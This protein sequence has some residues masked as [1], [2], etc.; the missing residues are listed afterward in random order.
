MIETTL[1]RGGTSAKEH[2]EEETAK[3]GCRRRVGE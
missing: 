2:A 3:E 1:H